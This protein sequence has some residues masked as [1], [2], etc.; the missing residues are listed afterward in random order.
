M[1]TREQIE[2]FALGKLSGSD[3]LSFEARLAADPAFA[4]MVA[5]EVE[6]VHAIRLAPEVDALKA[7]L[8]KLET[9]DVQAPAPRR[10]FTRQIWVSLAA[11]IVLILVAVWF[12]NRPP[13]TTTESLFASYFRAPSDMSIVRQGRVDTAQTPNSPFMALW[14]AA[15]QDYSQAR[16]ADAAEKLG[17][18]QTMAE[19]TDYADDL[20]YY[21]ALAALQGGNPQQA[22]QEFEKI[23]TSFPTEKP[24]YLAL[25]KL[26]AG[27]ITTAKKD[28][29]QIGRSASPFATEARELLRQ[30]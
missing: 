21:H 26:K 3:L 27:Q 5:R 19:A 22:I 7:Q 28:L 6:V 23:K 30:L 14:N 11:A 13:A 1:D 8:T 17:R 18:L 15:E 25:A 16:F 10:F 24:W 2:L 9:G 29:E 4:A 12:F 20:A